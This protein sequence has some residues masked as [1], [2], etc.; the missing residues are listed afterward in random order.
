MTSMRISKTIFTN[1]E[2]II[3]VFSVTVHENVNLTLQKRFGIVS[4]YCD[5]SNNSVT[6][7]FRWIKHIPGVPKLGGNLLPAYAM[8]KIVRKVA[9]NI[10]RKMLRNGA[11]PP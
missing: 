6:A 3:L 9:I 2:C 10:C 8:L 7:L 4:F 5:T 1:V 11:A